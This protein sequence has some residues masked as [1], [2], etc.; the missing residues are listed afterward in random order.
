MVVGVLF[1]C[2]H[3]RELHLRGLGAKAVISYNINLK[4]LFARYA[5]PIFAGLENFFIRMLEVCRGKIAV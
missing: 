4:L 1:R 2:R 3:L 5:I